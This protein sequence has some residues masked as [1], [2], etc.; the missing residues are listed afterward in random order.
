[1]THSFNQF[2]Q[3]RGLEL[4]GVT[5]GS[6][7]SSVVNAMTVDVEDYYHVSGLADVVDR[8]SWGS[9]KSRVRESNDRLLQIFDEAGIKC[10]FFVLG[11]AAEKDSRLVRDIVNLGHEVACHGYG[12]RLIYE[13]KPEEF[14]SETDRAK[15]ILEDQSGQ[16]VVGYRAASFSITRKSLWALDTLAQLGFTYDSSIVPIRHDRYGLPG[17]RSEPHLLTLPS[18]ATIREFPPAT[19]NLLGYRLPIGG[20]GY[21]R[22]YPYWFSKWALQSVNDNENLP[23]VFYIHPWELDTNQPRLET[24]AMSKFRHYH[25]LEESEQ[26]LRKLIKH[27]KFDC[28]QNILSVLELP[29]TDLTY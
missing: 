3:K 27:F 26:R 24:N 12:H 11:W 17:A 1:M 4:D 23:F 16:Q 28:M 10:T 19:L 20:G 8:S 2:E 7:S 13:Q 5:A 25:N 6:K 15:K 29:N 9:Q 22:I 14:R 21:F 18:G